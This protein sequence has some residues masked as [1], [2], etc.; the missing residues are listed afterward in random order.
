[1]S[2]SYPDRSNARFTCDGARNHW[3]EPQC[4]AFAAHPLESLVA[5]QLLIALQPAS[6]EL[7]LTAAEQIE[8][9]R[10]RL[11]GHQRQS[12]ERARYEAERAWR[13]YTAVEP[14]HRL[15]ARELEQ[16][17]EA[18]LEQQHAAEE[19][20]DRFRRE[21]PVRLSEAER[22]RIRDLAADMP[23]LWGAEATKPSDRQAIARQLIEQVTVT[24]VNGSERVEVTIRWTGGFESRHEIRRPVSSYKSLHDGQRVLARV[25]EL[26]HQGLPHAEVA[27]RLNAEG[28]HGPHGGPFTVPMVSFAWCRAQKAGRAVPQTLPNQDPT[29]PENDDWRVRELSE[30]LDIPATTLNTWRRRGWLH[31]RHRSGPCGAHWL[32][33]A[34]A[35]E[36]QRLERLRQHPRV[37]LSPVPVSLITPT[38]QPPWATEPGDNKTV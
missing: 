5:R 6:L 7:S 32:Y 34:D 21:Q 17:W 16:R 2:V 4:Q 27:R 36:L 23:G 30:R 37:G 12:V 13:Q 8:A 24:V 20:L 1:M 25:L 31:A 38:G 11:E 28:F 22:E 26:K 35:A 3:G 18:S 10:Q 15:V 14:E 9:E 29:S 19:A 33:W